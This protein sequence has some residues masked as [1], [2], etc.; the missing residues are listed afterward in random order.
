MDGSDL[1]PT[2]LRAQYPQAPEKIARMAQIYMDGRT[3]LIRYIRGPLSS[4]CSYSEWIS[5]LVRLTSPNSQDSP[6]SRPI[7]AS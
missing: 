4:H 1:T 6:P 5:S 3:N 2:S 7:F